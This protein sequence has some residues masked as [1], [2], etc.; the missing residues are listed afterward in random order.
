[1]IPQRDAP[2]NLLPFA[3]GTR[4]LGAPKRPL[5]GVSFAHPR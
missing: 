4:P 2:R 3:V 5:V 1:M